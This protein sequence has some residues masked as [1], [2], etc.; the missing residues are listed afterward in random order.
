MRND[1]LPEGRLTAA[2]FMEDS[3]Y[4]V[5]LKGFV[6]RAAMLVIMAAKFASSSIISVRVS[7]PFLQM[8]NENE[9]GLEEERERALSPLAFMFSFS[10]SLSPDNR[11]IL[12][13]LKVNSNK[14]IST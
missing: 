5:V 11:A 14:H 7:R 3:Y 6:R 2:N 9:R 8:T 1:G 10:L 13:L 4:T 12:T